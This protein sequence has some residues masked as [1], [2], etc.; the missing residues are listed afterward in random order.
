MLVLVMLTGIVLSIKSVRE[1]DL[2]WQLRTGEVILEQ[3]AVPQTDIFSFSYE[4]VEWVNVKWGFEVFQA[5]ITRL[6]GPELLPLLQVIATILLLLILLRTITVIG[7][8]IIEENFKPSTGTGLVLLLTLVIIE[9]R[10]T[11]RPECVSHLM[12][13][14][15]IL[16]FTQ[17]RIR[18]SRWI[19]LLVPLQI[20]WANLHEA[21]GMG[22]VFAIMFTAAAWIEYRWLSAKPWYTGEKKIP[23]LMTMAAVLCVA[24]TCINPRGVQLLTH[25][26]E[27][28]SQ[29][30]E[31]KFTVELYSFKEA[32]FWTVRSIIGLSFI[33]VSTYLFGVKSELAGKAPMSLW[34]RL[35]NN[36]S[37]GYV[38]LI[39]AMAY[40]SLSAYRNIPFAVIAAAP[41]LAVAA[42]R[43]FLSKAESS[44]NLKYQLAAIGMGLALY[45]GVVSG[46]YYQTFNSGEE[47]GLKVNVKKAP[48]GAAAFLKEN[49]IQGKAFTDYLSSSYLLWYLQPDFKTYIDLR[50]LDIYPAV[51]LKNN[52][53]LYDM[54][55]KVFPLADGD[56]AFD[57]ISILNNSLMLNTHRY[58]MQNPTFDL[59]YGD[60]LSS[61]YL[62]NNDN[63]RDVIEK[64]G[65]KSSG[66]DVFRARSPIDPSGLSKLITQLFNP[67]YRPPSNEDVNRP[68]DRVKY[69]QYLGVTPQIAE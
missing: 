19:F 45:V 63:N 67:L 15:Y 68:E 43:W 35:V 16:L 8:S 57:Y 10:M 40:L 64:Y 27:I 1:P 52:F 11:G 22:I 54:P 58:L 3:R 24:A 61:L 29:L 42:D 56:M 13:A 14:A 65:V 51:F 6:G 36:I 47:Y 12:A 32:K 26:G 62:R 31:N 25:V 66:H 17:H 49:N 30:G 4:G 38:L 37:L 50:D 59:V 69:Y 46:L 60:A 55:D 39:I 33:L 7:Q 44:A 5:L 18:P 28:F 9:Y 41:L 2:W 34:K 53:M 48:H 21:Y 20:L 23:K